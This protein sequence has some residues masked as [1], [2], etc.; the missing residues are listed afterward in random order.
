MI[1]LRWLKRHASQTRAV[2]ST[3]RR[4]RWSCFV[5]R[6]EALEPRWLLATGAFDG[7]VAWPS[8]NANS[9]APAAWQAASL[10]VLSVGG[11]SPVTSLSANAGE[12][13][14]SPNGFNRSSVS[15]GSDP[16]IGL[17]SPPAQPVDN[18]LVAQA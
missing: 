12:T 5:G 7:N 10:N 4:R 17:G 11:A 3:P 15:P 18:D 6:P 8:A 9:G 14:A 13:N 16:T 1:M 2:E